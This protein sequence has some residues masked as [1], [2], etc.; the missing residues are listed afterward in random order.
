ML[1]HGQARP[2]KEIRPS[3]E[4]GVERAQICV[5]SRPALSITLFNRQLAEW[6]VSVAVAFVLSTGASSVELM[7]GISGNKV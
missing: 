5:V 3:E 7:E 4:R 6:R 2:R 1:R